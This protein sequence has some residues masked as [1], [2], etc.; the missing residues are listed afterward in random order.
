MHYKL[1]DYAQGQ[2]ISSYT[3]KSSMQLPTKHTQS[4]DMYYNGP[5]MHNARKGGGGGGLTIRKQN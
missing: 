1:R 2:A 4:C 3:P 5:T